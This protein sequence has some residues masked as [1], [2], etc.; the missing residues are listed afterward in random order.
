MICDDGSA[1]CQF[2]HVDDAATVFSSII[3]KKE[4]IGQ[5]Y[6]LVDKQFYT[7]N[8]YHKVA[9][10][11]L[12]KKVDLVEVAY[13][14]LKRFKIPGFKICRDVFSHNLYFSSEKLF[15]LLPDFTPRISLEEG[16][17]KVLKNMDIDGRIKNSYNQKWEDRIIK[18]KR[19][20]SIKSG[21]FI[22]NLLFNID[23]I[24][25]ALKKRLFKFFN[26]Y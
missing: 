8:E 7:W 11:V 10:K 25:H 19:K 3:G 12:E 4:S 18:K 24:T 21:L 1:K 15:K 20:G 23:R 22:N 2:M 26:V 13:L 6:N 9:M 5:V 14:D 16:M 17:K